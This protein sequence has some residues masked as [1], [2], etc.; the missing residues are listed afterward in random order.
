MELIIVRHA[1]P[2]SEKRDDGPADPPLTSLGLRQAEATADLLAA[3]PGCGA[4]RQRT[5]FGSRG[6]EFKSPHPDQQIV[7]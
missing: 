3:D 2:E 1:L 7:W 4:V 5:C 6:S